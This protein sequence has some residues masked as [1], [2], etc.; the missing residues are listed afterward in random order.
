MKYTVIVS[1][2]GTVGTYKN[3]KEAIEVMN[4]YIKQSKSGKGR[5]GIGTI[6]K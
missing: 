6:N 4:K 3:K 5:A 2:I 1:N